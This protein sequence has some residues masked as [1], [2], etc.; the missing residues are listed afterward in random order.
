MTVRSEVESIVFKALE[1][2]NDELPE[3]SKVA[4]SLDTALF[5]GEST[6]DSLSLV[7]VIID[8]ETEVGTQ[9][10]RP[11]ALTDDRA[12]SRD[13]SPFDTVGTLVDYVVELLTE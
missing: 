6:V 12:M 3:G 5:G 4:A 10:D 8:V 13:P 1:S 9:Y 11:I 2:L 7:S